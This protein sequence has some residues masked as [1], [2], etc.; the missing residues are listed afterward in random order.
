MIVV[1]LV[2]RGTG[3][4][5]PLWS[6]T[7]I[8]GMLRQDFE[9]DHAYLLP[10][11]RVGFGIRFVSHAGLLP[12]YIACTQP[13]YDGRAEG[14]PRALLVVE[15]VIESPHDPACRDLSRCQE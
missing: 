7:N 5:S 9:E 3:Q 14:R 11:D 4:G 6:K 13:E 15:V 2:A 12:R 1:M 8:K 10:V